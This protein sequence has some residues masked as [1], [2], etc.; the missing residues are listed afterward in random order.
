VDVL[1]DCSEDYCAT[2]GENYTQGI[3]GQGSRAGGLSPRMGFVVSHPFRKERE[4]DGTPGTRSL[5]S[6][7]GRGII[8]WFLKGQTILI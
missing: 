4:M 1:R 8:V 2:A 6:Y 3:R 7:S 5:T